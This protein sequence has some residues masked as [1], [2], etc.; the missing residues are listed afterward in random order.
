LTGG[1]FLIRDK[2]KLVEM[3]EKA[4]DSE[5]LLQKLLEDYPNLLAGDQIDKESPR[6]WLLIARE[7]NLASEQDGPSRWSVDHLFLDQDGIPT[8]IE[9]K[10]SSDTRIRREVVGQMLEYASNGVVYWPVE[11]LRS[12]YQTYWEDKGQDP[13]Q[14]LTDFLG[15]DKDHD[16]F[17]QTVKTNLQAGKVRMV[18]VADEIPSELRRVVEFLN[19]QMD[20]AEVLAVEMKQYVGEGL[21]TLVPRVIGQTEEAVQKKAVGAKN[22]FQW[23]ETSFFKAIEERQ[24]LEDAKVARRILDWAKDRKLKLWWGQGA[25]DGSF[26]PMVPITGDDQVTISV[27]TYGRLEVQFMWLRNRSPFNDINKRMELLR[28]F[29]EIPGVSLPQDSIEKRP[30]I[31]LARFHKDNTISKLLDILDWLIAELK[32]T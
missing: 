22:K 14:V 21:Q 19:E 31:Q 15:P 7:M 32:W 5:D 4:Y 3:T 18:F 1:I 30:S 20:P 6:R 27:W 11:Q 2:G 28:R 12:T 29:N 24:G 10:R 17:W 25:K 8:I 13:K 9:V 26:F 16:Q 23:D